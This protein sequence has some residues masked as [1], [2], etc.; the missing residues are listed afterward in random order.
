MCG[1]VA[2]TGSD[3]ATPFLLKG[4]ATLEYRGPRVF[5]ISPSPTSSPAALLAQQWD[6]ATRWESDGR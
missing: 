6:V 1:I 2:Y 4:L 3:Q 5:E